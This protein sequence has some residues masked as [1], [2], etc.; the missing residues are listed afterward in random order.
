M[1]GKFLIHLLV[2]VG[3]SFNIYAQETAGEEKGSQKVVKKAQKVKLE[4][5]IKA[6]QGRL[7]LKKGRFEVTPSFMLGLNDPFT[8]TMGGQIGLEYF[9]AESFGLNLNFGYGTD[10]TSGNSTFVTPKTYLEKND[11]ALPEMGNLK[12]FFSGGATWS[13][14][15]GKVSFLSQAIVHFDTFIN[16]NFGMV[17]VDYRG[18]EGDIGNRVEK[19][20]G[21]VKFMSAISIGQR[22]FLNRWLVL[23]L[24]LRDIIY[25]MDLKPK[26]YP[27][28]ITD[29][30]NHLLGMIGIGIFFPMQFEEEL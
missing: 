9:I 29:I 23:K 20:M 3:F 12:Y 15:Y 1:K 18:W 22:V 2:L 17:G 16:L 6:V 13:P 21:G 25:T 24:E 7:F 11:L 19:D 8:Q 5:R 27:E 10:I 14:I 4:D 26:Y 28:G 30:Q